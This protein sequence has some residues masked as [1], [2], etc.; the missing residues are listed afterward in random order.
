M[1]TVNIRP[2]APTCTFV[3]IFY[4]T[5]V[6]LEPNAKNPIHSMPLPRKSLMA[7]DLVQKTLGTFRRCTKSDFRSL[8]TRKNLQFRG[9]QPAPGQVRTRENTY[10]PSSCFLCFIY[11]YILLDVVCLSNFPSSWRKF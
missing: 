7:E 3:S 6:N 2:P 5:T 10:D 9:T 11:I 4:R 8:I 1:E